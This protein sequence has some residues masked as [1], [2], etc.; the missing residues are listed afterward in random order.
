MLRAEGNLR[1]LESRG[2]R[3]TGFLGSFSGGK[4]F[5]LDLGTP[6]MGLEAPISELSNWTPPKVLDKNHHLT[7]AF[8]LPYS[9][10]FTSMGF[11]L[12]PL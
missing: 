12:S 10:L 3:N 8:Y 5:E 1:W 2:R 6:T 9:N 11:G 7:L 4:E